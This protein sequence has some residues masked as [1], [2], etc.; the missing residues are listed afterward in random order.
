[1]PPANTGGGPEIG[2]RTALI[3][4]PG[5]AALRQSASMF[6][7]VRH[8][9][10]THEKTQQSLFMIE[11][12]ILQASL[13]VRDFI[14]DSSPDAAPEYRDRFRQIRLAIDRNLVQLAEGV[15]PSDTGGLDK[16]RDQ[17]AGYSATMEP[18]FH[19]PPEQRA[20]R[21]TYFLR[22]QQRPRRESVLAIAEQIGG[23]VQSNYKRRYEE[24]ETSE[25]RYRRQL[26][27]AVAAAFLVG[28]AVALATT[29]RIALLER[30][31]AQH[32]LQTEQAEQEMRR[33]SARLMQAQEDERRTISREL[34]DEVG[35]LLT[36]LRMELGALGRLQNASSEDFA[37]HM[38]EAKLLAEQTLRTVRD[39]AVGLRPSVLDLGLGPA[40]Q[41]QARQ[42]SR[43]GGVEASVH[44]ADDPPG[45]RTMWPPASTGS[46]RRP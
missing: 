44:L 7:Q 13:L 12:R 11:R 31:T 10:A 29:W 35:Q 9:Q 17:I 27:M 18:V 43:R 37:S 40:L 39:I 6:E 2:C 28:V 15:T 8:I 20:T 33:P 46:C 45:C 42:F 4:L 16:L 24:L 14:L 36:A 1:M 32:Q 26:G 5:L 3:F 38:E 19:W 22:E 34:H 21:G 41:W 23:L 30:R 25:R